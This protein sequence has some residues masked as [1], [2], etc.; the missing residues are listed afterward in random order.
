M[1]TYT[2]PVQEKIAIVISKLTC[3]RGMKETIE[4]DLTVEEDAQIRDELERNL[5]DC[6][7]IINALENFK[8]TM[9]E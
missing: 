8:E 4:Y 5:S 1:A 6:I 2:I 7:S 3:C 9:V